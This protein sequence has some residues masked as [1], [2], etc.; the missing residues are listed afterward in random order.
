VSDGRVD[1]AID[2]AA[3]VIYRDRRPIGAVCV[4]EG[5]DATVDMP[6]SRKPE[7]RTIVD[8]EG[9]IEFRPDER[10]T[11]PLLPPLAEARDRRIAYRRDRVAADDSRGSLVDP[12][13]FLRMFDKNEIVAVNP[14][15]VANALRSGKGDKWRELVEEGSCLIHADAPDGRW[16]AFQQR[17]PRADGSWM[18]MTIFWSPRAGLNPV[19]FV[20]TLGRP[21]GEIQRKY[22][23]SWK[24]IDGIHV[25]LIVREFPAGVTSIDREAR[26]VDCVLNR[27]LDP[28]QFDHR[29]L[30]MRDGDLIIDEVKR[31]GYILRDGE[32]VKLGDLVDPAGR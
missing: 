14:Q 32:T 3:G 12:R 7:T 18:W 15:R 17:L 13:T 29:G 16:Y 4:E 1:F 19:G 20:A 2:M 30:G 27:P 23:W 26:L 9:S 22:E 5:T 11:Y 8:K 25:P 6:A 10:A 21:D 28:H 31:V 24:M